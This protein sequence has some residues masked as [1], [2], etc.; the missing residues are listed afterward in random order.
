MIYMKHAEHG[1]AHFVE[2][3]Q[4]QREADGWVRWPRTREQ[5]AGVVA[6]KVLT[7]IPAGEFVRLDAAADRVPPVPQVVPDTRE[8]LLAAAAAE[9]LKVDRRWSDAR[10]AAELKK[11]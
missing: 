7:A 10:L 8:T 2:E 6:T 9:G 3:E 5:K 4:A 11:G 1:N